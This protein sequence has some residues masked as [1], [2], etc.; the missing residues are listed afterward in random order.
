MA[1]RVDAW[2][3]RHDHEAGCSDTA[4]RTT[5]ITPPT[6]HPPSHLVVRSM[7]LSVQNRRGGGA[8]AP[9]APRPW[10]WARLSLQGGGAN[11]A[12]TLRGKGVKK[13]AGPAAS[14]QHAA[15]PPTAALIPALPL[16]LCTVPTPQPP[17]VLG[18]LLHKP[19]LRLAHQAVQRDQAFQRSLQQ[20]WVAQ[21]RAEP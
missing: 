11:G 16:R 19:R 5:H 18:Q 9:P 12:Q 17:P 8:P 14:S 10:L 7:K 2:V 4:A 20:G 15:V 13:E 3:K 6:H 21:G 1:A